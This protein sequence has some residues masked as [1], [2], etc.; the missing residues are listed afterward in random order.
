MGLAIIAIVVLIGLC[1]IVARLSSPADGGDV[2]ALQN[3]LESEQEVQQPESVGFGLLGPIED[4]PT[5]TFN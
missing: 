5:E 1:L 3:R 2:V 4:Q